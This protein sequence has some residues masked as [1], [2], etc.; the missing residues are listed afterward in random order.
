MNKKQLQSLTPAQLKSYIER[1]IIK[2]VNTQPF[3]TRVE[4]TPE[5]KKHARL[6]G[7]P[8]H[9]SE[10]SRKYD[11]ALSTLSRYVRS[12]VI[13]KIKTEKNRIILDEAR[14]AYVWEVLKNNPDSQGKWLFDKQGL[15]YSPTTTK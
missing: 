5:Y 15:P 11:I 10:A 13:T 12:G 1:G 9:L 2:V 14:V 3:P 7:H 6:A 4:E 8:I